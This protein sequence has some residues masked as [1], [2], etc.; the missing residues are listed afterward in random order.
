MKFISS[1]RVKQEGLKEIEINYTDDRGVNHVDWKITDADGVVYDAIIDDDGTVSHSSGRYSGPDAFEKVRM[2]SDLIASKFGRYRES[3]LYRCHD[4]GEFFEEQ[5]F[6]SVGEPLI[7]SVAQ[8][9][10]FRWFAETGE[11]DL[12][13]LPDTGFTTINPQSALRAEIE[14]L[15][16]ARRCFVG[17]PVRELLGEGISGAGRLE[18]RPRYSWAICGES[19]DNVRAAPTAPHQE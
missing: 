17:E 8:E 6:R 11:S 7:S 18:E 1:K 14:K 5:W 16:A 2:P 12:I 15:A 9:D 19:A 10:A 3:N 13:E 4:T